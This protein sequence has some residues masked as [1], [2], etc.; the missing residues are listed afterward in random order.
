MVPHWRKYVHLLVEFCASSKMRWGL[1]VEE[2][3]SLH[4]IEDKAEHTCVLDLLFGT[5]TLWMQSLKKKRKRTNNVKNAALKWF[6]G[7]REFSMQF[8]LNQRVLDFDGD[9][10]CVQ[11]HLSSRTWCWWF[12]TTTLEVFL[13]GPS[14]FSGWSQRRPVKTPRSS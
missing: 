6:F 1:G 3:K 10:V 7:K 4:G 8:I 5:K 14:W 11:C 12:Y 13:P 2:K 9:A